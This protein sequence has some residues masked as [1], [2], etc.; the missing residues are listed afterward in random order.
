MNDIIHTARAYGLQTGFQPIISIKRKTVIGFEALT[1]G[2]AGNGQAPVTYEALHE[3][4]EK[5]ERLGFFD[6]ACQYS[7]LQEWHAYRALFPE[8][9][10]FINFD[11]ALINSDLGDTRNLSL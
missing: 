11:V 4:A 1:R 7:A 5:Q 9:L 2:L 10:L 8:A 3:M 6:S